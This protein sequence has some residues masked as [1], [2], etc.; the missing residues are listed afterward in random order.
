VVCGEGRSGRQAGKTD[1]RRRSTEEPDATPD[2]VHRNHADGPARLPPK[3]GDP[4]RPHRLVSGGSLKRRTSP[5]PPQGEID[6]PRDRRLAA[7]S[8]APLL[9]CTTPQPD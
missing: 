8:G 5:W 3:S 9:A 4:P 1:H 2:G 7:D 6:E